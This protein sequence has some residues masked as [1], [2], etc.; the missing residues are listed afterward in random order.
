MPNNIIMD[1]D[2]LF[3]SIKIIHLLSSFMWNVHST[4]SSNPQGEHTVYAYYRNEGSIS[5]HTL[6]FFISVILKAWYE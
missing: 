6:K 3:F 5:T 2:N 1:T 4:F